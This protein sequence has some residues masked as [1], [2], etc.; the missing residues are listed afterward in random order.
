G[1]TA[2]VVKQA[3]PKLRVKSDWFSDP[4]RIRIEANALRFLPTIV[5]SGMI[6]PLVF[7]DLEEY[8]LAMESVP[9]PHENWKERLLSGKLDLA[10]I[11]EFG[12]LLGLIHQR[13]CT[14]LDELRIY[15]SDRTFFCTLRIEPYYE[16][17]AT[18]VPDAKP[19]LT[20]LVTDTLSRQET[21]VHGDFSPKN[22]LIYQRKPVLL[23]HEVAHFGDPAFDLGFS[24][25]HL[26]SKAHHLASNRT[27]FIDAC[28]H[29]W[30]SYF[31]V[32]CQSPWSAG[33]ENRA[34][35][36]TTAC[37]LARA[38]GRS[39]LEYLSDSERANQS[40]AAFDLIN[41]SPDSLSELVEIFVR[42]IRS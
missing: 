34:V 14:R 7:E 12:R 6:T 21:F 9:E 13:S 3:L 4:S 19:F 20:A 23:D 40:R 29:Y 25:T 41:A 26:L 32:V 10:L 8:I 30:R 5:P 1:G 31:E 27:A 35:K 38:V 15:F 36:H 2:W 24:I 39:P 18:I 11:E 33:L 17:S 28:F 37:L 42:G 16:Y 22:I